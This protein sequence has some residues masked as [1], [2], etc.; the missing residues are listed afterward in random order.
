M[1]TKMKMRAEADK[2]KQEIMKKFELVKTGKVLT[3]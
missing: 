2:N 1:E 3:N